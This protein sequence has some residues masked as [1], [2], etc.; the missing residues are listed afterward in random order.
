MKMNCW[1]PMTLLAFASSFLILSAS[2]QEQKTSPIAEKS[3]EVQ[4]QEALAEL[5][6][7]DRAVVNAQRYCPLM[8]RV[9][10]GAMG[11]PIKV[12][13]EGTAVFV[14]CQGCSDDAMEHGK[15]TLAAVGKLKKSVAAIAKLP[16]PDQALAEAQ[17]FCPIASGSRLGGM[18]TPV[19]VMLD[20]QPVFL[21]CRSC[22][23][24]AQQNRRATL[25]RVEEIKK[26]NAEAMHHEGSGHEHDH[27]KGGASP[28]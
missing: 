23:A 19:K 11:T 5:S 16:A 2:A 18:G 26:A 14:C 1:L 8:N 22:V 7:P 20:G 3:V 27:P 4:V 25:A 9:R 24:K 10:L 28:K 21:C 12:T 15:E 17:F 13:I 6:E